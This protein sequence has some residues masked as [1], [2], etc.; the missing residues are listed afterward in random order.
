VN[1]VCDVNKAPRGSDT[2]PPIGDLSGRLPPDRVTSEQH[3]ERSWSFFTEGPAGQAFADLDGR[4]AAAN[5]AFLRILGRDQEDVVGRTFLEL[6]HPDDRDHNRQLVRELLAGRVASFQ[7]AKRYLRPDETPIP[8]LNTVTVINTAGR[9]FLA[10]V[11]VELRE[12]TQLRQPLR[13]EIDAR[14]GATHEAAHD[15]V[16]HWHE[17]W[18]VGLDQ[19]R[20]N[21][22]WDAVV[23]TGQE[24]VWA[25][26]PDGVIR[27]LS[28]VA[29]DLLGAAPRDLV[30]RSIFEIIHPDDVATAREI[31]ANC[32]S[33]RTNSR[34]VRLRALR[35]DGSTPWLESS[36]VAHV[37]DQGKLIG[38]TATTRRLVG[39][40]ARAAQLEVSRARVQ[41]TISDRQLQ[42]VWQPI[43]SLDSGRITGVEALTRFSHP[44]INQS[45]DRWFDEAHEAGLG[46]QLEL[47]AIETA[48]ASARSLPSSLY[49]SINV[50]PST[51]AE[52]A[53][54]SVIGRAAVP[55][56]RIVLELTEHVSIEDYDALLPALEALRQTGL[57]LAVDDAG[58][59]FASFRHILRLM[60]DIIK[61][62]QSITR[63]IDTNAAQRALAAALVMFAL[64]VGSTIVVAEGVETEAELLTVATLG[65]DAVQGYY[66]A[67][68]TVADDIEYDKFAPHAWSRKA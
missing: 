44:R 37:D 42:T 19:R 41:E 33:R 52:G 54:A 36:S 56:D 9:E 23:N 34:H 47:L 7:L 22:L 28:G 5:T 27:Y 66:L 46:E 1:S 21:W 40:E 39:D 31:L 3:E 49:I 20:V 25:L 43:F 58:A 11:C 51:V 16:D 17:D 32:L 12:H 29:A 14:T 57:R 60:P 6:T 24:L 59:G 48:L 65:I 4:L 55:A 62:D 8:V 38:F 61:L 30:G 45:V 13:V 15:E 2:G 63:G 35:P 26:D 67:R 50:S 10:A 18:L 64:D 53:V 68:P